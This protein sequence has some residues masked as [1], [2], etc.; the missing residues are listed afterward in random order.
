[1][2]FCG[3]PD[4]P[5]RRGGDRSRT[6]RSRPLTRPGSTGS[7]RY[8]FGLVQKGR[9]DVVRISK[10]YPELGLYAPLGLF[11]VELELF[12][13]VRLGTLGGFNQLDEP[14]NGWNSAFQELGSK[15]PL[16]VSR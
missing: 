9:G 15:C 12:Q 5:V 6:G 8:S 16:A 13:N 10:D 14:I 2:C 11:Q 4:P 1:M 7:S 3:G